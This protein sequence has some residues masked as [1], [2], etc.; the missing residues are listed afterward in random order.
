[1]WPKMLRIPAFFCAPRVLIILPPRARARGFMGAAAASDAAAGAAAGAD[2]GA[3]DAPVDGTSA[4]VIAEA[5]EPAALPSRRPALRDADVSGAAQPR[6]RRWLRRF[7][8]AGA[9]ALQAAPKQAGCC[10]RARRA[11]LQTRAVGSQRLLGHRRLLAARHAALIESACLAD[12]DKPYLTPPPRVPS[13]A[14][15]LMAR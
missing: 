6:R 13:T 10:P 2:D 11:C 3:A 1:M 7:R 14:S 4:E 15:G 8:C 5:A 9:V 12:P